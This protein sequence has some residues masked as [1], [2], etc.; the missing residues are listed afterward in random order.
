MLL[1]QPIAYVDKLVI[2][3]PIQQVN[4]SY[5][6]D[7]S[8]V[9]ERAK[10]E[11]YIL[12]VAKSK[13][14]ERNSLIVST[15]ADMFPQVSISSSINRQFDATNASNDANNSY[16][17]NINITQPIF[18]WGK[19]S[20]SVDAAKVSVEE[21]N[22]AYQTVELDIL[23]SIAKDYI[24]V[25][26]AK[27]D[28][29]VIQ[30][31]LKTAEQFLSNIKAKL[32]MQ[33]ATQLDLL[34]AES[35]YLAVLP[36]NLRAEAKYKKVLENLANKL[37]LDHES[38]LIL[39]DPGSPKIDFN[40]P[41]I[42]RSD[43]TQYKQ[44]E[45]ICLLNEK[46]IKANIYP[47]FDFKASYGYKTHESHNLFKNNNKMWNIGI[48]MSF[49][50]FDGMRTCGKLAEN[51]ARLEQIVNTR[52]NKEREIVS[53]KSNAERELNKTLAL[54][55]AESKAHD[56]A[57]EALN[58]SRECFEQGL[59]TSLDLLQAERTERQQ[60]SKRRRAE[61]GIWIAWFDYRHSYGLPPI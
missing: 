11:N 29:E 12:R 55:N 30:F 60:E 33:T 34:R 54:Y 35:E 20:S 23:H 16:A 6:L 36:E 19:F 58:T 2:S 13:I 61:L 38:L 5:N 26:I 59:I 24:E 32:D 21:A 46:I 44:Q 51:K 50:I 56:A 9:L 10:R 39:S 53:E 25:L 49:K 7:L 43:I 40:M 1:S 45:S 48:A 8:S 22:S 18:Y 47:N 4:Q 17:T 57:V 41:V 31:R 42:T 15:R 37:A 52:R 28:I 27:A 14:D 3:S